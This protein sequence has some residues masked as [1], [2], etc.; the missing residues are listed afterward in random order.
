MNHLANFNQTW[1]N[2]FSGKGIQ[3]SSI[4]GPCLFPRGDNCDKPKMH[5]QYLKIFPCRTILPNSTKLGTKHQRILRIQ[6]C[7]N[8]G[9]CSFPRG[10]DSEMAKIN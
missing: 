2:T 3:V 8:E 9:S 1:H 4:E 7:A 10:N 5:R 6:V